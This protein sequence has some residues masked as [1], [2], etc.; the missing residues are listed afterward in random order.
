MLCCLYR[1]SVAACYS[2]QAAPG[3]YAILNSP[4][5]TGSNTDV[6]RRYAR[7]LYRVAGLQMCQ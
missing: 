4:I 1:A 7:M 5:S 6:G 3:E 2:V